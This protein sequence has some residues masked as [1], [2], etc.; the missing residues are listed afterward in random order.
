ML[1]GLEL[2]IYSSGLWVGIYESPEPQPIFFRRWISSPLLRADKFR[3]K[4][5]ALNLTLSGGMKM[6]LRDICRGI[7]LT[8]S[9]GCEAV[10]LHLRKLINEGT[11]TLTLCVVL[12][13]SQ[14]IKGKCLTPHQKSIMSPYS[15][16]IGPLQSQLP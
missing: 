13:Q 9:E 10:Y 11:Y 7:Q 8:T 12:L 14:N 16:N 4:G 2:G 6:G 5:N 15:S 3:S 1:S